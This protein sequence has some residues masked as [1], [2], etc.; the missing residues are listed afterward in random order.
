M[1][2]RRSLTIILLGAGLAGCGDGTGP[3]GAADIA[4][5]SADRVLYGDGFPAIT[6]VVENRGPAALASVA[7]EVDALRGARTVAHAVTQLSDVSAGEQSQSEPAVFASLDSHADFECYRY[8][9]RGY[10][11]R[12]RVLADLASGEV[13]S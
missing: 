6:F 2:F 12:A 9:V 7:I 1:T 4:V 5:L 13:C 10:D 8:R 3:G 11:D